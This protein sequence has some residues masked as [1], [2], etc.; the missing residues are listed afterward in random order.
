MI[1]FYKVQKKYNEI[2]LR[3]NSV[4]FNHRKM[5]NHSFSPWERPNYRS[6]LPFSKVATSSS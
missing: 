2:Q 6:A 4:N 5:E 1:V 3:K